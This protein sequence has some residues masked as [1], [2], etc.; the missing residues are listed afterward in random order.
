METFTF[1]EQTLKQ[2]ESIWSEW[3]QT[4]WIKERGHITKIF[5]AF[6]ANHQRRNKQE[7][8]EVDNGS[9]VTNKEDINSISLGYFKSFLKL[10]ILEIWMFCAQ[11]SLKFV[12]V[13][14]LLCL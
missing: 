7:G 9:W 12:K 2:E 13:I 11:L 6:I 10:I 1:L 14:I 8:L 5:H 4:Q 3:S